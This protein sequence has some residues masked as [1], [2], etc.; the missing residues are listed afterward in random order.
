MANF[1]PDPTITASQLNVVDVAR[2]T[3]AQQMMLLTALLPRGFFLTIYSLTRLQL[4]PG[5]EWSQRVRRCRSLFR[6]KL[7]STSGC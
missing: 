7:T 2:P 3:V 1:G 6:A 5:G 4:A